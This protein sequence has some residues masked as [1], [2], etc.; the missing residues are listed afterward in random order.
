MHQF[1]REDVRIAGN[2][3]RQDLKRTGDS[4]ADGPVHT[5]DDP[6]GSCGGAIKHHG[7]FV[8]ALEL[9]MRTG[10]VKLLMPRPSFFSAA[11]QP[12]S[13]RQQRR[14]QQREATNESA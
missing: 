10:S 13:T 11:V 9:P 1:V 3:E 2:R 5:A 7:L 14:S 12:V 4:A 6:G 8:G